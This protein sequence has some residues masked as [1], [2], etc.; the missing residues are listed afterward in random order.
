MPRKGPIRIPREGPPDP[1][2]N[3]VEEGVP[4]VLMPPPHIIDAGL[5]EFRRWVRFHWPAQPAGVSKAFDITNE[6]Q[7]RYTLGMVF[8][9]M[10]DAES[11]T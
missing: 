3:L 8:Q 1:G 11:D 10:K 7:L 6:R 5:A 4:D 2:F 9:A